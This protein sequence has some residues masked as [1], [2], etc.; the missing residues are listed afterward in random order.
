MIS[1]RSIRSKFAD[2]SV[3][4]LWILRSEYLIRGST[5]PRTIVA[6]RSHKTPI[7]AVLHCERRHRLDISRLSF[8][9]N[10]II[11]YLFGGS[12]TRCM[13]VGS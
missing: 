7:S 4:V 2:A 11:R 8:L 5:T 13:V 9:G 1:I 10:R 3:L 6:V 12:E